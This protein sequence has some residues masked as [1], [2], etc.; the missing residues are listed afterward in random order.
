MIEKWNASAL[1]L[2]NRWA[3]P[4]TIRQQSRVGLV[5]CISRGGSL[6]ARYR[7]FGWVGLL[8]ALIWVSLVFVEPQGRNWAVLGYFLGSFSA[9]ATLAAAWTALGPGSLIYR[10]PLSIAWIVSLLFAA[11]FNVSINDGP[12]NGVFVI[13]TLMSAQWL[14][15]QLPLWALYLGFG[16]QLRYRDDIPEEADSRPIRFGIRD[17]FVTMAIVG[18]LL[19]IGRGVIANIDFSNGGEVFAFVLLGIAGMIMTFPLVVAALM[20]RWALPGIGLAVGLIVAVTFGEYPVFQQLGPGAPVE[21]FISINTATAI[22]ILI[23]AG[24]VRLNGYSLQRLPRRGD[25]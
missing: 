4:L 1:Q 19:G 22:V 21:L 8:A 18:V 14:L 11:G 24:V 7:V 17:L 16:F 5:V 3:F 25:A 20:Q 12:R 10:V 2:S 9:C 23:V 6:P 13:G 15:M